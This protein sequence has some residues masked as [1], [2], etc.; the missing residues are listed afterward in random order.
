MPGR[1]SNLSTVTNGEDESP[2]PTGRAARE[3]SSV[4]VC[5]DT[6]P[7]EM[8]R[9]TDN[10][11]GPSPTTHHD[12]AVSKGS[13]SSQ[14]IN[15]QGRT[16]G[17]EQEL[18]CVREFLGCEPADVMAALKENEFEHFIPRL[19]AELKKYN[20][21]QCDK[22]NSYRRK[23]REE[24]ASKT[25]DEKHADSGAENGDADA[26]MLDAT[27]VSAVN[28][29]SRS[30]DQPPSKKMRREAGEEDVSEG[31][32][33]EFHDALE[34]E[35]DE[36][37][38]G[39]GDDEVEEDEDEDEDGDEEQVEDGGDEEDERIGDGMRD[40]ALDSAEDSD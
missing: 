4:E 24:K 30:D 19:E 39:D 2:A 1:K 21:V 22:R 7:D 18:Y 27:E 31:D 28:G 25:G 3:G 32:E 6:G 15:S 34:G 8:R 17:T 20:T 33:E 10:E 5:I 29:H 35:D 40:E 14:H 16:I 36:A 9:G 11:A 37:V 13:S 38:E 12:F 23:I 26:S